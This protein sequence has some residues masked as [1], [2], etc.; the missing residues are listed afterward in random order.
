M[1]VLYMSLTGHV[2]AIF[3][4][5]SEPAKIETDPSAF[6]GD[7]YHLRGYGN[8][9]AV[10]SFNNQEFV[11]PTSEIGLLRTDFNATQVVMPRDF[12]VTLPAP[13]LPPLGGLGAAPTLGYAASK[14]TLTGAPPVFMILVWG[15]TPMTAPGNPVLTLSNSLTPSGLVSGSTYFAI[16]FVP[17]LEI[18][19]HTFTA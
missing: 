5:V 14:F 7:G 2:L 8:Q 19:I 13:S 15:P 6:L 3:T 16:A 10:A 12:G 9:A 18:A 11:I 1:D 17:G 4:R